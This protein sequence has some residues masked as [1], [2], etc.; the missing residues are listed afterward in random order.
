ML[1]PQIIALVLALCAPSKNPS[2]FREHV[3]GIPGASL[4]LNSGLSTKICLNNQQRLHCRNIWRD[5]GS[6]EGLKGAI[7]V[8]MNLFWI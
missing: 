3:P 7:H 8:K 1:N 5:A 6:L 2:V 4:F